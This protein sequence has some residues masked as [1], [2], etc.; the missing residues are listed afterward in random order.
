MPTGGSLA[1]LS[2]TGPDNLALNILVNYGRQAGTGCYNSMVDTTF[3]FHP[4]PVDSSN[5]PTPYVDWNQTVETRVNSSIASDTQFLEA[6]FDST[7]Q[8]PTITTSPQTETRYY[9]YH[10]LFQARSQADT[11][12]YQGRAEIK[13]AQGG[14]SFWS[15]VDWRDHS[16]GSGQPTWGQLRADHRVGF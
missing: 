9:A 2:L 16:D 14:G 10:I 6:A 5:N 12:R 15:I 4:D 8:D 7:Y 11:T 1:C 3:H 13:F